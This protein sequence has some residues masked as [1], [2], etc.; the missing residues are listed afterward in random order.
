MG[1]IGGVNGS[2]GGVKGELRVRL[3]FLVG[4]VN[5]RYM[6]R[7]PFFCDENSSSRTTFFTVNSYA[8]GR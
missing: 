3:A 7:K 4:G 2:Y 8:E 1:V 5:G 6:V